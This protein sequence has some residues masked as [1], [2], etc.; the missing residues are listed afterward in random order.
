M[1]KTNEPFISIIMPVQNAGEHL[2][3]CLKS[4]KNQNYKNFEIIAVEDK[5]TDNSFKI[6]KGFKKREKRLRPYRNVKRY[7][8]ALTL[9]RALKRAKGNFIA[10][11]DAR[12]FSTPNR[13]KKQVAYLLDNPKAVAVGTQCYFLS[14]E[15]KRIGKSSFPSENGAIYDSFLKK[16]TLQFETLMINKTLLPK[17]ILYFKQLSYPFIYTEVLAK[18]LPYGKVANLSEFLHLRRVQETPSERIH[19]FI[20][21][22]KLWVKSITVYD[23]RPSLRSF[24]EPLARTN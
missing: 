7:G 8:M 22:A 16:M 23:Y 15:N 21:M 17:D 20:N 1:T 3:E 2:L 5:S 14:G 24:V 18:V 11:M 19:N 12:D 9:N 10:F 4:L 6:L 13:L